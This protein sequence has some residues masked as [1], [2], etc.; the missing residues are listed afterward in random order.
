[1]L[2]A[3]RRQITMRIRQEVEVKQLRQTKRDAGSSQYLWYTCKV[4]LILCPQYWLTN[5]SY[6]REKRWLN[7]DTK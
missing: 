3:L 2:L 4:N 1:M 5:K 7:T 6:L